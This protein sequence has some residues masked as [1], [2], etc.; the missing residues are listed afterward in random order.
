MQNVFPH[1]GACVQQDQNSSG[2][3]GP[4]AGPNAY[5]VPYLQYVA[6]IFKHLTTTTTTTQRDI[7]L[8]FRYTRLGFGDQL[9]GSVFKRRRFYMIWN[10]LN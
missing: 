3:V 5:R 6:S 9:V 7:N 1:V 8:V 10:D 2:G 4:L